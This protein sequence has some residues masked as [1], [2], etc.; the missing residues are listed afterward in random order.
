MVKEPKGNALALHFHPAVTGKVAAL[1]F[2]EAKGRNPFCFAFC[3][4]EDCLGGK[5]RGIKGLPN[6]VKLGD[7]SERRQ[8]AL[9]AGE[10]FPGIS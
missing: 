2:N 9:A 8:E 10:S 6:E 4:A 3:L 5:C 7:L 1:S